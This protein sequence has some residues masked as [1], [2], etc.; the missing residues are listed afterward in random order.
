[1]TEVYTE[2]VIRY[3]EKNPSHIVEE[4]DSKLSNC[5]LLKRIRNIKKETEYVIFYNFPNEIFPFVRK[6]VRDFIINKGIH[7]RLVNKKEYNTAFILKDKVKFT[8]NLN[9]ENFFDLSKVKFIYDITSNEL[10]ILNKFEKVVCF[11]DTYDDDIYK[12]LC[13]FSGNIDLHG[14]VPLKYLNAISHFKN[15]SLKSTISQSF[16]ST[17][18]IIRKEYEENK[19]NEIIKSKE[20]I[21]V[22]YFK[23]LYC[24][25][26]QDLKSNSPIII[27][28][29]DNCSSETEYLLEQEIKRIFSSHSFLDKVDEIKS[30]SEFELFHFS[31]SKFKDDKH[32]S[33]RILL[34]CHLLIYAKLNKIISLSNILDEQTLTA[35]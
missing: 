25:A 13:S 32:I 26:I 20:E 14:E 19:N 18:N 31:L 28:S 27:Y 16:R 5:E 21:S 6:E 3:M 34:F 35:F 11:S 7:I 15:I 9:L 30:L 8:K 10:E 29:K 2:K 24:D 33:E 12:L 23:D 22:L 4:I 1:M 17:F